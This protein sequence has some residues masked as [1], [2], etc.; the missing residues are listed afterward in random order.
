MDTNSELRAVRGRVL[1][2]DN[3]H[4]VAQLSAVDAEGWDGPV[5]TELLH[6]VRVSLVRPLVVRQGLRGAAAGEAES[7]GWAA[8]WETLRSPSLRVSRSPWGVV[9][10]AARRA[11]MAEVVEAR[12][13]T[14][15]RKA[16][17]AHADHPDGAAGWKSTTLDDVE[18]LAAAPGVCDDATHELGCGLEIIAE[19]MS[20]AGWPLEEARDI[21]VAIGSAPSV[22]SLARQRDIA[23][24]FDIPL[25]RVRR[26]VSLLVGQD[27]MTPLLLLA[28]VH[29]GRPLPAADVVAALRVT[30]PH[31]PSR[32]VSRRRQAA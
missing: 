20:R 4:L 16:W 21:L 5:A 11:V 29:D 14:S 12:Y 26:L 17:A 18:R 1:L 22:T 10:S 13:A 23:H 28:N 32:I 8:A 15:A 24:Q 25:V 2:R 9:W 27:G 6:L 31:A 19:A 3:S 7:S 30:G